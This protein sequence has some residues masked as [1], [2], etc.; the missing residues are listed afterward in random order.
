MYWKIS[1]KE[2]AGWGG[3]LNAAFGRAMPAMYAAVF[4]SEE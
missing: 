1:S 2:E 3:I 4:R